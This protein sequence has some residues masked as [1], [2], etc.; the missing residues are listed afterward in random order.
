ME[1]SV[2]RSLP[3]CIS[4]NDTSNPLFPNSP[5][6]PSH[7]IPPALSRKP[8]IPPSPIMSTT[9]PSRKTITISTLQQSLEKATAKLIH[10][11]QRRQ[12]DGETSI[13]ATREDI[14]RGLKQH[15]P[16]EGYRLER[17]PRTLLTSKTEEPPDAQQKA[18]PSN[19]F[20]TLSVLP[21]ELRCMIYSDVI[22]AGST[23]ILRTSKAI[24]AEC[25]YSLG[26]SGVLR[27]HDDPGHDCEERQPAT[28]LRAPILSQALA[29]RIQA[30]EIS[31]YPSRLHSQMTIH[32]QGIIA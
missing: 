13:V 18:A 15:L 25:E 26:T 20:G 14:L 11:F 30:A 12:L 21:T 6:P 3:I 28:P 9:N 22:A 2:E 10:D 19:P 29:N 4:T 8:P 7:S 32:T 27:L 1:F 17:N 31:L 5:K 23:A 16:I 24:N